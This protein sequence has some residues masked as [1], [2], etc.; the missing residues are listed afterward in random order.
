MWLFTKD[1]FISAVCPR[2]E[3]GRLLKNKVM[4][5]ARRREHLEAILKSVDINPVAAE[6][7]WTPDRDYAYRVVMTKQEFAFLLQTI[8]NEMDYHN[9]KDEC[10]AHLPEDWRYHGWLMQ[11]WRGGSAMQNLRG[12]NHGDFPAEEDD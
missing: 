6:V 12:L 8:A 3:K 1:G 11:V 9:F 5:R 7:E 4:V 10:H 2:S